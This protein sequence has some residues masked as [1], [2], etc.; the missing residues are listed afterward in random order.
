MTRSI[1]K[2]LAKYKIRCNCVAPG[3]IDTPMNNTPLVLDPVFKKTILSVIPM[4]RPGEAI[5]VAQTCLF[6]ASDLSSYITG[7]SIL[8]DGGMLS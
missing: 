6:L 5:E 7:E 8:C 1:A 3:Y 2:E 4:K